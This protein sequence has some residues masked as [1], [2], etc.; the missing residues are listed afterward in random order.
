MVDLLKELSTPIQNG[1]TKLLNL[2]EYSSI[3]K[4]KEIIDFLEDDEKIKSAISV[5]SNEEI[6][7]SI[8]KE[9]DD[10]HLKDC[11][12]IK[13]PIKIG[14]ETIGSVGIIGPQRIDYAYVAGAIKFV[15]DELEEKYRL[16]NKNPNKED[17]E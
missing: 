10:D 14:D 4:A 12:V 13:A 8:G 9:N 11:A 7:F 5:D 3:E 17:E 16:E 6:S 2:P 15:V 1:K